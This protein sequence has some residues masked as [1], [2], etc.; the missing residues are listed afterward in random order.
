MKNSTEQ[1]SKLI[2]KIKLALATLCKF[3]S[4]KNQCFVYTD[5][6]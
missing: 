3:P 5:E 2:G 4:M 6:K 1:M